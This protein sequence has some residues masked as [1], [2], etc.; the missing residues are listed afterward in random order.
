MSVFVSRFLYNISLFVCL[1]L[2]ISLLLTPLSLR[3]CILG[4][5]G[6]GGL[7]P[8]RAEDGEAL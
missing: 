7:L 5:Q 2:T 6:G 8:C 4:Q 1:A 3:Q